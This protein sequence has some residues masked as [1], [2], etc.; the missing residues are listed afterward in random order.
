MH[1]RMMIS[2]SVS[3]LRHI[4]RAILRR[5]VLVTLVLWLVGCGAG[6]GPSKDAGPST[7]AIP[8]STPGGAVATA[9][10]TP[11]GV[12]V[13]ITPIRTPVRVVATASSV[14]LPPCP[15][16]NVLDLDGKEITVDGQIYYLHAKQNRTGSIDLWADTDPTADAPHVGISQV[17]ASVLDMVVNACQQANAAS[18]TST[19]FPSASA[20]DGMSA[21]RTKNYRSIQQLRDDSLAVAHVTVTNNGTIEYVD[22]VPFT[23]AMATVDRVLHGTL[24]EKSVKIRQLGNGNTNVTDAVPLL[25]PGKSYVVFLQRFTY[26]PGKDTDQYIPASGVGLYLDQG[27]VLQRVDPNSS[28]LPA[29]LSLPDLERQIAA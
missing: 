3:Q 18:A 25:Q 10:I 23:I 27:G 29:T 15:T 21:S 14:A 26:G 13:V 6:S 17:P 28:Q 5:A 2:P 16:S 20:E 22:K 11:Q 4:G 8:I 7:V 1:H 9:T 24:P 19:S 12:R